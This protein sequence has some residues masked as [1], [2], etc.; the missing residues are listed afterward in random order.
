MNVS[1]GFLRLVLARTWVGLHLPRVNVRLDTRSILGASVGI[2]GMLILTGARL[3][4]VLTPETLVF[5]GGPRRRLDLV[6]CR[7]RVHI[8]SR[9]VAQALVVYELGNYLKRE[10]DE[11]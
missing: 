1:L 10:S 5:A 8:W 4:D 11:R 6:L 9:H 3:F 7:S 2:N